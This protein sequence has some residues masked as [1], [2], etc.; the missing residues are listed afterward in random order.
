MLSLCNALS[1][2]LAAVKVAFLLYSKLSCR[3][4]ITLFPK[5]VALIVAFYTMAADRRANDIFVNFADFLPLIMP[6]SVT[7][8]KRLV[9]CEKKYQGQQ[10]LAVTARPCDKCWSYL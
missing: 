4:W 6:F 1:S 10:L 5:F 9:D 8:E 7:A 2:V 3:S